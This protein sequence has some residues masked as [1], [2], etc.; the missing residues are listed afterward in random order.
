MTTLVGVV[1]FYSKAISAFFRRARY[2]WKLVKQGETASPTQSFNQDQLA[3]LS[4]V[5]S[6]LRDHL[7]TSQK[8]LEATNRDLEEKVKLRTKELEELSIRD[9]LTGLYNRRHFDERLKEEVSR[10]IRHKLN[11]SLIYIDLD[12]F[13]NYNDTNGH[14]AGDA[15]LEQFGESIKKTIRTSTIACRIGGEEFCI[16]C[17]HTDIKGGMVLAE[18][19][20]KLTEDTEFPNGEKQPLGRVTCSMGVSE[21]PSTADAPENLVSSA[22]SALYQA[23]KTGRNRI[24]SAPVIQ[25]AKAS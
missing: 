22:D 17:P 6:Q 21:F 8:E 9:A 13:K 12:N 3:I 1:I 5:Y 24:V 14:P 16:I 19:I 7:I 10:S 20:R 11:L 23:K 25:K 2:A 4:D 15:L 18:K